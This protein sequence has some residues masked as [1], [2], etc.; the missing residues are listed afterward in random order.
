M[1][2]GTIIGAHG[3]HGWLKVQCS[4]DFPKDR[5]CTSG[6]RHLKPMNKRA[7]REVNLV[8]GKHRLGDE[9]LIQLDKIND[10]NTAQKLRGSILYIREEQKSDELDSD[11]FAVS[12]LVGSDVYLHADVNMQCCDKY[13]GVVGGIVFS[14]DICS[15]PGIGHD[16]LE[17]ILARGNGSGT[18]SNRDEMV[19]IPIVAAI[20]TLVDIVGRRIVI[21][22]PVGLL[23]L[24][25]LKDEKAQIKGFLPPAKDA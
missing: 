8:S 6:I 12:D 18:K 23:N 9:Y 4:T 16:Y 25:Y 17:V 1:L 2:I 20:V 13:V 14:D 5:L 10:R 19:L 3:V 15:I 7:P 22:P 21:D 11:E 24:T